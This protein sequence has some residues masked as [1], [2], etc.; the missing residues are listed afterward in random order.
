M[1]ALG[2][3]VGG[4]AG[5]LAAGGLP[6]TASR[7]VAVYSATGE[8]KKLGRFLWSG[9]ALLLTATSLVGILV[10]LLRFWIAGRLY[11]TPSL[12]SY[13]HFFVVIMITGTLA[14]FL[15]QALA[16]YKDV[17]RRTIITS[18]VG[19]SLTMAFTVTLVA[20]GFGFRGY[21]LAQVASAGNRCSLDWRIR[22]DLRRSSQAF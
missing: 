16:G 9:F 21:L 15:G 20:L 2:M 10:L 14:G 11:H 7:F 5:V 4:L 3:T 12:S 1:Y 19:Q 6:Q 18:F 22:W 13:L 8:S 17:A